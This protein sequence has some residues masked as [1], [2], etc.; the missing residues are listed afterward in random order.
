MGAGMLGGAGDACSS[1]RLKR[2]QEFIQRR[3]MG[4]YAADLLARNLWQTAWQIV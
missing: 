1:F 3:C 4:K 2:R